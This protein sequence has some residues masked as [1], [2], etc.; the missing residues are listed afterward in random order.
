[1]IEYIGNYSKKV[2]Y[3]WLLK[4]NWDNYKLISMTKI[5]QQ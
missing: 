5:D 4:K 3:A 1:M 2:M